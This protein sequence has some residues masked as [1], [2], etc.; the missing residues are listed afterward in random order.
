M[1]SKAKLTL[2]SLTALAAVGLLGC[3]P[4]AA[5][6]SILSSE[7]TSS[8]SSSEVTKYAVKLG[9]NE[10]AKD[11]VSFSTE[12]AAAG[13]TVTVTVILRDAVSNQV[14]EIAVN[15]DTKA[16]F[17]ADTTLPNRVTGTFT[18]PEKEAVVDVYVGA[19]TKQVSL[20]V[21]QSVEGTDDAAVT[22]WA[23]NSS[24]SSKYQNLPY[25]IADTTV[26]WTI[27]PIHDRVVKKVTYGST[28]VYPD[29]N[30]YYGA[31]LRADITSIKVT[32]AVAYE[33]TANADDGTDKGSGIT[34]TDLSSN[35]AEGAKVQ[36][37]P[38]LGNGL[39]LD[40][41]A[42]SYVDADEKTVAIDPEVSATGTYSF[43]MP[44]YDVKIVGTAA[45]IPPA[46]I[47]VAPADEADNDKEVVIG[48]PFALATSYN[49]SRATAG[50]TYKS[51]DET[52]ATVDNDGV[53]TGLKAG[54]VTITASSTAATGV[55]DTIDLVVV[56][57]IKAK[58]LLA[59]KADQDAVTLTEAKVI[60]N[61]A[62][63]Y[64]LIV[65]R[66]D[67][68]AVIDYYPTGAADANGNATYTDLETAMSTAK[69]GDYYTITG[70][71]SIDLTTG[72][73]CYL[74]SVTAFDKV[75]KPTNF[76]TKGLE[77]AA[78]V[79]CSDHATPLAWF[80]SLMTMDATSLANLIGTQ[81][82]FK[83]VWFYGG[84]AADYG[85]A[86]MG[87]QG[88]KISWSKGDATADTGYFQ[89]QIGVDMMP[90][91]WDAT[92][93]SNPTTRTNYDVTFIL[94]DLGSKAISDKTTK[95]YPTIAVLAGTPVDA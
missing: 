45:S 19:I 34:Y 8:A 41:V 62:D 90:T 40:S 28:A 29:A 85:L 18:M 12:N 10:S 32:C 22:F 69:V 30:G 33:V 36:F 63:A 91:D 5:S 87:D 16:T 94:S 42:I 73:Y 67:G 9:Y 11:S 74:T 27:A 1:K 21:S 65:A 4:K 68:T 25:Y 24:D 13:T 78:T 52:I 49:P 55:E 39:R 76:S 83:N 23:G 20:T 84:Y 89:F 56:E 51:S 92:A 64:S 57:Q 6:S 86:I 79:D 2:I 37:T 60:A 15:N 77:T 93:N 7:A 44:A 17:T 88:V 54:N 72:G 50:V 80:R 26:Y 3:S 43:E 48:T 82:T 95:S 66:P 81:I 31:L 14:T 38:T 58:N 61:S 47:I 59:A 75:E 53:V 46:A 35:Y 71:A 70:S